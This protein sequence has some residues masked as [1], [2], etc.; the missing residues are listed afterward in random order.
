MFGVSEVAITLQEHSSDVIP[1]N[2]NQTSSLA[3]PLRDHVARFLSQT[4]LE[5][6]NCDRSMDVPAS[7]IV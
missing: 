4:R 1:E 7:M 3:A 5:V 2:H 6:C